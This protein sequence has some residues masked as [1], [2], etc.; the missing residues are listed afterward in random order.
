ME[1][2]PIILLSL[3]VL[4]W[5]SVASTQDVTVTLKGRTVTGPITDLTDILVKLGIRIPPQLRVMMD[6][7]KI[8]VDPKTPSDSNVPAPTSNTVD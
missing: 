3:I 4:C 5:V 8:D 2:K 1:F 6:R 7:Y